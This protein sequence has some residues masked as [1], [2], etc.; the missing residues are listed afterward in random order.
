MPVSYFFKRFISEKDE[1]QKGYFDT[2]KEIN[3]NDSVMKELI[4]KSIVNDTIADVAI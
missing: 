4:E 2:I 1:Y 3:E